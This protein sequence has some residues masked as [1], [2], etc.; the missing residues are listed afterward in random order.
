MKLKAAG[1]MSCL[2]SLTFRRI[3]TVPDHRKDVDARLLLILDLSRKALASL[4]V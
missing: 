4:H 1:F 2:L 3:L